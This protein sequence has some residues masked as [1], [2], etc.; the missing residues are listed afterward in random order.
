MLLLVLLLF[1][2]NFTIIGI[3]TTTVTNTDAQN[4]AR[5]KAMFVISNKELSNLL[6]CMYVY[7]LFQ[8]YKLRAQ[9]EVT[10]AMYEE[11]QP[12]YPLIKPCLFNVLNDPCEDNNLADR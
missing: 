9:A 1:N 10:C 6:S 12:C 11:P 5:R 7:I 4:I 3:P 2:I 8:I